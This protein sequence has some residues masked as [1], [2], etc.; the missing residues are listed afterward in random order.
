MREGTN[1]N[2]FNSCIKSIIH[3]LRI[4]IIQN[5]LHFKKIA[6]IIRYTEIVVIALMS[7]HE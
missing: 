7:P 5:I 6:I 4:I 1:I 3:L 2:A